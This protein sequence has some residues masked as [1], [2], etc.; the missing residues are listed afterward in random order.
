MGH[1]EG[2]KV[3]PGSLSW[4]MPPAADGELCSPLLSFRR[5]FPALNRQAKRC[6]FKTWPFSVKAGHNSKTCEQLNSSL[7]WTVILPLS[8]EK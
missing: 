7:Q 1:Q 6:H 2:E 8:V 4:K 3:C 5:L